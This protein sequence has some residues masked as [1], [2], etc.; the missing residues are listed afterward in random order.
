MDYLTCPPNLVNFGP[1]TAVGEFF[2]LHK[3][4]HWDWQTLPAL[5]HGPYTD[6]RQTLARV[7]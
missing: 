7:M 5:P 2:P 4:S 1:E 6:N 3:F